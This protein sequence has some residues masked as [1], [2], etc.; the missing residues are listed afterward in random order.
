MVSA[1][2]LEL[3]RSCIGTSS[4]PRTWP[5]NDTQIAVAI[6]MFCALLCLA[7]C[8]NTGSRFVPPPVVTYILSNPRFDGDIEQTSATTYIVTQG[9]SPSVQ[10]VLAGIDPTT[11]TEF[12]AFLNFPLG[13]SGGVPA[14][15][16]IISAFL[17]VL[18]D[19][20]IPANGSVPIRVELVAFQPPT[21]I[22][23]DF[24]RNALPPF[25]AVLVSGNVTGADIGR[26]VPV[27][28]TSLMIH[29]Q[30]RGLVDFQVRILEE[31]GPPSFTL[32]VIDDPITADRSQ[33]APLLT[34]TYR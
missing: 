7:G 33:R 19:D 32:M 9:M 27:D 30:Q 10:S 4:R 17:E 28:V 14:N 29:A 5:L 13:G 1:N 3:L 22:G 8:D 31:L 25:G 15:A 11:R 24:D 6:C 2:A 20:L 16:S 12:R 23:T 34:V 26:F 21:L 18:V